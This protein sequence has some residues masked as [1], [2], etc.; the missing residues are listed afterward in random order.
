[1]RN[2]HAALLLG[3]LLPLAAAAGAAETQNIEALL[4]L[5]LNRLADVHLSLGSRTDESAFTSA[6]AVYVLEHNDIVRSAYRHLA[7]VLRLLPGVDVGKSDGNK[8]AV[9]VRNGLSRFGTA[10]LVM[11]DGRHVYTPLN[12]GVRWEAQDLPLDDIER[13]ELVR[14]PS[15]PLWGANSVDGIIHIITRHAA[16]TTGVRVEALAGSGEVRTDLQARYGAAH[17]N[18]LAWRVS[19]RRIE[20]RPNDY[21]SADQSRHGGRRVA[22]ERA[23]DEGRSEHANLRADWSDSDDAVSLHAGT[24]RQHFVEERTA[25]AAVPVITPYPVIEDGRFANVDWQRRLGPD[26]SLRARLSAEGLDYEQTTLR[27]FHTLVDFDAQHSLR[28][29]AQHITWGLGWRHYR[30]RVTLP[31]P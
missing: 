1:M 26:E 25:F 15:G 20:G 16:Q 31:P 9:A 8:W 24:M 23:L 11:I 21:V 30:S 7:D 19:A 22:G 5:D 18:G 29:G 2:R 14:G 17:A 13:I 4:A 28:V 12:G 10:T 6:A 27:E 3:A